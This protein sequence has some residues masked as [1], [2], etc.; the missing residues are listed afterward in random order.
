VEHKGCRR[1]FF[2]GEHLHPLWRV[3]LYL[4][5]FLV[6]ELTMSL[7]LGLGYVGWLAFTGHSLTDALGVLATGQLPRSLLL[8]LG[9]GRLLVYSGLALLL[10]YF[11]DREPAATMGFLRA[12]AGRDSA[13]GLALGLGTMLVIGGVMLILGWAKLRGGTGTPGTFLLDAVALL[14]AAAA[15]EVAFRG[16][17]QRV[18]TTWKGPAVSVAVTSVLFALF[19]ALNPNPSWPAM[20]NIALAG[21]VFGL[22]VERTGTL[23]L[24][25]GYH[26]TW[27]LIQGPLL[28]MPVSGMAWEGVLAL[29]SGGPPLLTGG[30]FGPEGG[31]LATAVLLLSL[32][33]L[34]AATR[35][36]ASV[37][38]ACRRQRATLEAQF[39]PLPHAHHRLRP[40]EYLFNDY[41]RGIE[42]GDRDGEVVLVLRRPDGNVLLHTKSFY[43]NGA[44]RLPSG[45]IRRGES[46]LDA[47]RREAEEETG[48]ALQG[49][50]PLCLLTYLLQQDRRQCFFHSWLMMAEVEGEPET[51]D[52][53]ERI[54]D[55]RWIPQDGLT[56]VVDAL[57][58]LSP[59]W[60]RWGRFRALSHT[61]AARR[62][63]EQ[64]ER[65]V[66]VPRS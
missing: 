51:H 2:R 39:G 40:G 41:T 19:H 28:G 62:V 5:G 26:F 48:L 4:A 38:A 34:W 18:L 7:L 64:G 16:Y 25:V 23:W 12:R 30:L 21:A 6:A 50:R 33:P 49:P 47:A 45:G 8:S 27:N 37:A 11:L 35:R 29:G 54:A 43:P 13:V 10:G 65:T 55:F 20:L 61:A 22:A 31:L 46:V 59:Q 15:E 9:F 3:A 57:Q 56:E 53:G 1:F 32:F 44:Y 60:D 14:P 58:A 42:K 66:D 17:L 63:G 24:A 52:A 36:P